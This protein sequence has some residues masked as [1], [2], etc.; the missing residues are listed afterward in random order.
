[1]FTT[2]SDLP[3]IITLPVVVELYCQI[4]N[5]PYNWVCWVYPVILFALA[6]LTISLFP[7]F[8]PQENSRDSILMMKSTSD[9]HNNKHN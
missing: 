1:M 9:A 4:S 7:G 8:V 2:L 6:E 5:S 3:L